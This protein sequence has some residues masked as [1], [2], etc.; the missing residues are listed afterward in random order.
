M[1]E[2]EEEE[3]QLKGEQG[4][5]QCR[6]PSR[7]SSDTLLLGSIVVMGDDRVLGRLAR[8]YYYYR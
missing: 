5:T 3:P 4:A 7:N 6:A 1:E 8:T 2:Q